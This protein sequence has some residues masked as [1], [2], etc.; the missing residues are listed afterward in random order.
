MET[1]ITQIRQVDYKKLAH[2][3]LIGILFVAAF[4][5]VLCQKVYQWWQ[6]G[7]QEFTIQSL[8]KVWN[9]LK[10]CYS[11]VVNQ[12]LPEVKIAAEEIK[13]AYK[14]TRQS[15]AD[16]VNAWIALVTVA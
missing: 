15:C 1:I 2:N 10:V 9:I 8:Q 7:G 6:N 11:W 4:V 3:V 12:A 5:Y 16:Y 13:T 14:N